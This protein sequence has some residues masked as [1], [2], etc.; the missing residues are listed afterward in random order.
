M[1]VIQEANKE[2]KLYFV[3]ETKGTNDV[4]KL[5]FP[6]KEK[7]FC[8]KQHFEITDESLI[9]EVVDILLALKERKCNYAN[10]KVCL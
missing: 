4:D 9:Y 3:A 8:G 10:E 7:V 5:K 1:V 6:E 2:L